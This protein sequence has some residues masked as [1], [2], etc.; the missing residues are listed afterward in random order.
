MAAAVVRRPALVRSAASANGATLLGMGPNPG[1]R[2]SKPHLVIGLGN[3]NMGDEGVGCLLAEKLAADP[4]LPQGVEVADG[5]ADLLACAGRMT[6]RQRITLIDAI[7]DP[8]K[9]GALHVFDGDFSGLAVDQPDAH[10]LSAV[11]AVRLLQLTD[12]EL[13]RAR[14]KLVAVAIG[15]AGLGPGLSP[16]LEAQLPSLVD[17]V[18]A[19]LG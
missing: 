16:E 17:R 15:S 6:G 3:P 18:L 4:R 7:L 14:F 9:P 5:G 19:E 10:S 8:G 12:P 2:P 13:G 1:N 11:A